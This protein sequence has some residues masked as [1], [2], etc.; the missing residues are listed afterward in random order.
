M[1]RRPT[2]RDTLSALFEAARRT[3]RGE[4]PPSRADRYPR[5]RAWL[6]SAATAL[7][8]LDAALR[9]EGIDGSAIVLHLEGRDTSLRRTIDAIQFHLASEY[10]A[11]LTRSS[12][13]AMPGIQATNLNDRYA[14]MRFGQVDAL[15]ETVRNALHALGETL[16]QQ[17]SQNP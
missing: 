17:A 11:L 10:P 2:L 15:P 7:E 5:T 1:V 16:S 13:Y 8:A 14:I 3:L 6:A 12:Q 4:G 9:A